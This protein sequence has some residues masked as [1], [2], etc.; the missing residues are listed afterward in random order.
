[1]DILI[2]SVLG[3]SVVLFVVYVVWKEIKFNDLKKAKLKEYD[4]EE[5]DCYK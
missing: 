1:M 3:I 5:W 2:F 4:F